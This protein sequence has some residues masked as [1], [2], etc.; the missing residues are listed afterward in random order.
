MDRNEKRYTLAMHRGFPVRRRA[1]VIGV[2]NG[3]SNSEIARAMGV[4]V[5]TIKTQLKLACET[6]GADDRA[7]LVAL[8]LRLRLI[9]FRDVV[10]PGE[11]PGVETLPNYCRC[12]C[13]GCANHCSAH[14]T[15]GSS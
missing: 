15:K 14:Q 3:K 10:M 9:R 11:C 7:G 12:A 4:K 8:S 5:Y 13:E 2:A 6:V 1:V